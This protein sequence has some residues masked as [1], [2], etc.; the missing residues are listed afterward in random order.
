MQEL[1]HEIIDYLHHAD[2]ISRG[3]TVP[4]HNI[5]EAA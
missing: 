1:L 5:F 2:A 4:E 3:T